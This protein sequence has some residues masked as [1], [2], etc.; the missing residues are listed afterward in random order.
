MP[1]AS[2]VRKAN[3]RRGDEDL[4]RRVYRRGYPIIESSDSGLRRGLAFIAFA[5]TTSTQFEFIMRAW[6]RNPD[7]PT[8]G[9]GVDLLLTTL[10]EAVRCGGYYFVPAIKNKPWTWQLPDAP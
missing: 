5:R 2:H 6:L 7:F 9:T 4:P 10:P 1:L 8:P 3:P